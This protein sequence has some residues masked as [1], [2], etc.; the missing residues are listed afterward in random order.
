MCAITGLSLHHAPGSGE[1]VKRMNLYRCGAALLGV[2]LAG[3]AA[4]T[5]LALAGILGKKSR[6]R[7]R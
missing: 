1:K 7:R 2:V 3:G 6:A 5:D 4:A